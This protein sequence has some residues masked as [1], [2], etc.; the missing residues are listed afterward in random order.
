[1]IGH[2]PDHHQL[3][4]GL[5]YVGGSDLSICPDGQTLP[6]VFVNDGQQPHSSTVLGP[7]QY[8]VVGP[9]VVRSLGPQTHAGAV[10]EP[11]T[12]SLGLLGRHLQPFPSPDPLYSLVVHIPTLHPQQSGDPA[13]TVPAIP[14]GQLYDLLGQALLILS[15]YRLIPM[16]RPGMAQHLAGSSPMS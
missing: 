1:M 7:D 11:Q 2:S 15:R 8:E 4:K 13:I 6:G 12:S 9:H 3:G 10:I 14:T 5:Y 16:R